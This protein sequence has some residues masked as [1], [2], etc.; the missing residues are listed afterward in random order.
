MC[1]IILTTGASKTPEILDSI[2]H[3]G[4]ERSEVNF[5]DVTLCHHRLPIQTS[6]GDEWN[7]PIEISDGI[8]LMFNG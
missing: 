7:Q 4:I 3:R 2:K 1:G 8:Y 6:D 5:D